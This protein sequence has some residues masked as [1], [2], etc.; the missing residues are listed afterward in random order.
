VRLPEWR[1]FPDAQMLVTQLADALCEVAADAIRARGAFHLVL[2][3]G[4]TPQALYRELA[5]RHAGDAHWHIWYGDERCLPPDDPARNSHM[6]EMAWLADSA[7]PPPQRRAIPAEF[8]A[9]TAAA[10]YRDWLAGVA[11]F[12]LS[13]LGMGEDG[14]TASLFPG[15][16][17]EGDDVIAVHDA[18]KPPA[19]RVSLSAPRLSR[20]QRVWFIVTGADKR[21]AV[22]RW[23]RNE[24]LP[25]TSVK[26]VAETVVWLDQAAAG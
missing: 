12:D 4:R 26:G 11:N 1:V 16:R 6:A 19:D 21:E 25:V 14:H 3:G 10:Q 22:A 17:G 5:S 9:M 13:L 18:P 23:K 8:G 2:A 24:P 15:H 20:S 7:I